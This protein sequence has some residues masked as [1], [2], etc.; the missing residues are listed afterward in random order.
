MFFFFLYIF[1]LITILLEP[2]V[3]K[4]VSARVYDILVE[5]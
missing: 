1:F 3:N 5:G 2:N 4:P